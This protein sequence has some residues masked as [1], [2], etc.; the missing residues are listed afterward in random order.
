[1]KFRPNDYSYQNR[2]EL[3]PGKYLAC[4]VDSK[5]TGHVE[6][7]E[8][9]NYPYFNFTYKIIAPEEFRGYTVYDMQSLS[10]KEAVM[11]RFS[12]L[13]KAVEPNDEN[14]EIDL[15][16]DDEVHNYLFYKPLEIKIGWDNNPGYEPRLRPKG[17]YP[18]NGS[19]WEHAT[20]VLRQMLSDPEQAKFWG[21]GP[22]SFQ[23]PQQYSAQHSQGGYQQQAPQ[24]GGYA[25]QRPPQQQ[26]QRGPQGDDSDIPF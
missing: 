24:Q 3:G 22:R 14:I 4:I 23:D 9:K 13:F 20:E 21:S 15:D 16:N 6:R 11:G 18:I 8:G 5:K 7:R 26:Q 1:M 10:Q 19:D 17:W 12:L 2:R 25:N